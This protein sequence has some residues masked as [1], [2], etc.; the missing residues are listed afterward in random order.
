[1]TIVAWSSMAEDDP[2]N[3][4][5]PDNDPNLTRRI[6]ES[7][8]GKRVVV[9]ADGHS[10]QGIV[11]ALDKDEEVPTCMAMHPSASVQH[12]W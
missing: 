12:A 11:R 6:G 2:G 4:C 5:L 9:E 10:R 1:L 7:L 8:V 3:E